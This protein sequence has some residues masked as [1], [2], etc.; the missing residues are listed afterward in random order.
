MSLGKKD[1]RLLTLQPGRR[2]EPIKCD[3]SVVGLDEEP[4]FEALSYTWGDPAPTTPI[5]LRGRSVNVTSNL[6]GALLHLRNES[7][8]RNLWVDAVCINQQD[9]VELGDQVQHMRL[10][11]ERASQV[12]VWLGEASEDGDLAMDLV[13]RIGAAEWD[14][15]PYLYYDDDLPDNKT[16]RAL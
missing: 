10:I 13:A 14:G 6:Q 9:P 15:V 5:L 1:I 8:P 11:Y 16:R 3:L 2:D 7:V 4:L 12:L